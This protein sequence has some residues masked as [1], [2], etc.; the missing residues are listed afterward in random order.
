MKSTN[1]QDLSFEQL[2]ERLQ[3]V[4]DRLDQVYRLFYTKQQIYILTK[5]RLV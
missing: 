3:S 5:C 4:V 2:K 1:V